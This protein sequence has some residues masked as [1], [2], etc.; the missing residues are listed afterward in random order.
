MS[1]ELHYTRDVFSKRLQ[2]LLT[3][4]H[5]PVGELAKQ[6]GVAN[7]RIHR[8]ID[9]TNTPSIT[10]LTRICHATNTIAE[11]F[12]AKI[13]PKEITL[14]DT[15]TEDTDLVTERISA[16]LVQYRL[17]NNLS[18][19]AIAEKLGCT[20]TMWYMHNTAVIRPRM[21]SLLKILNLVQV[22]LHEVLL[23]T[24]NDEQTRITNFDTELR[25]R[26]SRR[27]N[28]EITKT[29]ITADELSEKAGIKLED[30]QCILIPRN[31]IT[32]TAFRIDTLATLCT[33]LGLKLDPL[34]S[35][36]RYRAQNSGHMQHTARI[37]EDL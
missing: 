7:T 4:K 10:V 19:S 1:K 21:A 16:Y 30:L 5:K 11:Y 8:Y 37:P 36:K 6:V 34:I 29:K 35:P 24:E 27:L 28:L 18:H 32:P 22:S 3:K 2:S 14:N 20:S 25:K 26:I 13:P 15:Y 12:F 31:P 9:G 33:Y 23:C 17:N